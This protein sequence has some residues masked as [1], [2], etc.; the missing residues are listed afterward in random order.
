MSSV[1]FMKIKATIKLQKTVV[2]LRYIK[3]LQAQICHIWVVKNYTTFEEGTKLKKQ[4]WI[5]D[6]RTKQI[7]RRLRMKKNKMSVFFSQQSSV[8]FLKQFKNWKF[9]EIWKN[10][11]SMCYFL[12]KSTLFLIFFASFLSTTSDF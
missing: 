9:M 12:R 7:F 1:S 6:K 4:M 3:T 2:C 8:I 10:I 11:F 5:C